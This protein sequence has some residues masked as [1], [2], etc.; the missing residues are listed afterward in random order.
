MLL[1]DH[2]DYV[3]MYLIA[4]NI[5]SI[6]DQIV[7]RLFRIHISEVEVTH[8]IIFVF[9]FCFCAGSSVVYSFGEGHIADTVWSTSVDRRG[10]RA[11]AR[12][13]SIV[14]YAGSDSVVRIFDGAT[15]IEK[16]SFKAYMYPEYNS[17]NMGA[18]QFHVTETGKYVAIQVG[19]EIDGKVIEE[20]VV[21]NVLT[22]TTKRRPIADTNRLVLLVSEGQNR[23]YVA[24]NSGGPLILDIET[25]DSL[26]RIP[27]LHNS[28]GLETMTDS[29][30]LA[31]GS[32]DI[33]APN[34]MYGLLLYSLTES[35]VLRT[36]PSKTGYLRL[37]SPT[38]AY[39]FSDEDLSD[40]NTYSIDLVKG[41][42]RKLKIYRSLPVTHLSIDSK[43]MTVTGSNRHVRVNTQTDE[44]VEY[45]R[46]SD[47]EPRDVAGG[48]LLG[49]CDVLFAMKYTTSTFRLCRFSV[50][51]GITSVPNGDLADSNIVVQLIPGSILVHTR[52][53]SGILSAQ[54]FSMQGT[55]VVQGTPS[56]SDV[57]SIRFSTEILA[58]GSYLLRISLPT[59]VYDLP[60]S[61]AK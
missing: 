21:H 5:C 9:V 61:L 37:A 13:G 25:L 46:T 14:A 15:G 48:D 6:L 33:G 12:N 3:V 11:V 20:L 17:P 58:T 22:G 50:E 52:D 51:G 45:L 16:S 31:V 35:R 55:L 30:L 43:F 40:G 26:G 23:I 27:E 44:F 29:T 32:F 19:Y 42:Q 57:T 53:N 7:E 2:A 24:M 28:F 18:R 47:V 39:V 59:G 49:S 38:K 8:Y 60:I 34:R 4:F 36:I 56:A 41:T 1:S 10:T 54:L